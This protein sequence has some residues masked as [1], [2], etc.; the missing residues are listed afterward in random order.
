VIAHR[1]RAER[2]LERLARLHGLRLVYRDAFGE[3]RRPGHE[4]VVALLRA[5]DAEVQAGD[6]LEP[7]L[8]A[9]REELT[10]RLLEPVTVLWQGSPPRVLLRAPAALAE[11][12][13]ICELE[14]EGGGRREWRQQ[15]S[16]ATPDARGGAACRV[17]VRLPEL[18]SG[19]HRLRV[20][21]RDG[22]AETLLLCAPPRAYPGE[23]EGSRR[24]WGVFLPLHALHSRRSWGAGDLADLA[25]LM[26]WVA[27]LGGS[28]VG[29]LPLHA[30]F[31]D[32]P[33][34][35]SPYAPASRLFWNEIFLA[36]ERLPE[37]EGSS[38][39]R[40]ALAGVDLQRALAELR[41]TE[42]VDYREVMARK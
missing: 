40:A 38:A 42:L 16:E 1:P 39:A 6:D 27:D 11:L 3:R 8:R 18:P 32:E 9:R 36:G 20:R 37:L 19:Y 30:A 2:Q 24:R 13:L 25:R 5:L 41:T 12:P 14:L 7:A 26:A 15:E 4:A 10:G 21:T 23:P 34:E 29:L 28:L 35:P 22:V 33:F 31:L 17:P